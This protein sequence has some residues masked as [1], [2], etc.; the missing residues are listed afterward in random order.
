MRNL[1][2]AIVAVT[3]VNV[4]AANRSLPIGALLSDVALNGAAATRTFYVGRRHDCGINNSCDPTSAT[5]NSSGEAVSTFSAV[6]LEL[7]YSHNNNGAL[8][9][10]CTEGATRAA[11]TGVPVTSTEAS[12]TYT[13]AWSGVAVT[14]SL[15]GDKKFALVFNLRSAPVVKCV[16][17]HGG[18]P[19]ADDT[20]TVKGWLLS[21]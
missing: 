18:A 2:F 5:D 6:R 14:P 17:S 7:D 11:A 4:S 3:G 10:T 20:I 1:F 13:L 16:V 15:S 12:G 21:D 19:D 8:T 9:L